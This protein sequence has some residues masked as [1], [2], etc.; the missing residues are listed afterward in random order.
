M[1]R[2]TLK[3]S[4]VTGGFKPWHRKWTNGDGSNP[5][6]INA[7][8]IYT[9]KYTGCW[10]NWDE[11]G[12]LILGL[13]ALPRHIMA[14]CLSAATVHLCGDQTRVFDIK[15]WQDKYPPIQ[16]IKCPE[17]QVAHLFF[18]FFSS[19]LFWGISFQM[20]DVQF[21]VHI[22][23]IWFFYFLIISSPTSCQI[24]VL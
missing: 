20:K 15:P 5:V 8:G 9:Y 23:T 11:T 2:H 3:Y 12:H 6:N 21:N 16:T 1:C 24:S 7:C 14:Y 4:L 22:V 13:Q 19:F 17:M 18:F 10:L